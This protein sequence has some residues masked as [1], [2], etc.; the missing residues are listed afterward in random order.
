MVHDSLASSKTSVRYPL[1][2]YMPYCNLSPNHKHFSLALS[3]HTEP[4]SYEEAIQSESWNNAIQAELSALSKTKTWELTK[5]PPNK[6]AIRCRWVFKVKLK[7]DGSVE[8]HKARLV[9][10]RFTRTESL[11]NLETFSLVVKM[12]TIRI[13]LS[14]A[15]IHGWH[16]HQLDVNTAFL[17]GDLDE[18][19]YMKP[20]PGLHVDDPKLV[21]KLERSLYGLKQASRQWNAKLTSILIS[22]GYQQAKADYSLFTKYTSSGRTMI[23]VYV[24]D[25]V[26]VGDDMSEI[27]FVK[28][29]LD[30]KFSIKDLGTLK[31][32][33][34]FAIA[35]SS[36][37]ISLYQRKYTLD[38]LQ[39]TGLIGSKP[40]ATPMDPTLKLH[41]ATGSIIPDASVYRR[42]IG[43]LLYLTH[44]RP[45]ISYTVTHLSQF[46]QAPTD[47]HLQAA[48]R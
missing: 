47:Q 4:D 37:G 26:L 12:T 39:D 8:R 21:C 15:A 36:K 33:L 28:S 20:P 32:F 18:E 27:E 16:L 44:T 3:T 43:R 41:K 38:L 35:R 2:Q 13:L 45:D 34:G 22:C 31:Y 14:L 11:D 19:V 46:L 25:L 7:A 10:K 23:L 1:S 40:C 24:D 29:L 9:A 42:L 48:L 5:L 30:S 17:H 6:K